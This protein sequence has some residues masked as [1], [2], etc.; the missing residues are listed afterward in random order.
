[1]KKHL[2]TLILALL[3]CFTLLLSLSAC[4]SPTSQGNQQAPVD[5]NSGNNPQDPENSDQNSGNDPGNNDPGV[6]FTEGLS[7]ALNEDGQSYTLVGLGS[8]GEADEIIIPNTHEGLSVTA[9]G[10]NAFQSCTFILRIIIPQTV[11]V[12]GSSAFENCSAL[13]DIT[14]PD[15]MASIGNNAFAGCTS[16]RYNENNG[17]LYIGNT[18]NPYL[19][20]IKVIDPS[21][22]AV[23]LHPDVKVIYP[24]AFEDCDN[25]TNV[26]MPD[27]SIFTP[28]RHTYSTE[29]SKN[30]THHWYD[31]TCEHTDKQKSYATHEWDNGTVTA[32][33]TCGSAGTLTYACICGATKTEDIPQLT[34]HSYSDRWSYDTTH[35]WHA[36]TCPHTDLMQDQAEHTWDSGTVTT[37]ATCGNAGTL[38]YACICGATKTEEIPQLTEHS[39]SDRWSYDTTHHWHAA[40]CSHSILVQDYAEHAWGDGTVLVSATCEMTGIMTYTCICGATKT[41][42]IPQLTEHPYSTAWSYDNTHHWHIAACAH[43]HLMQDYAEH[44]WGVGTVTLPATCT[45][46][47]T[48]TYTCICGHQKTAVIQAPGHLYADG[49]CTQCGESEPKPYTRIDADGTANASGEYILFGSYPQ[50]AVTDKTLQST[51]RDLAGTRPTSSNNY[52]WTS[53]GYYAKGSVK[54]YMWYID[55]SYEGELYRGVY[56]TEYRSDSTSS[57]SGEGFS[58][59]DN[60]GYTRSQIYWFRYE[61]I[62]WRILTEENG[63]AMLLCEMVIDAQEYYHSTSDR[64]VDEQT[65]YANNYAYSNIRAW[66]NDNFYH[67]AFDDLQKQIIQ[68]TTVDNSASTTKDASNPYA[69]ENTEDNVFLLS[70]ADVFNAAYGFNS[71]H[72]VYNDPALQKQTTDYAQCQGAATV[73]STGNGSWWLRSPA[74]YSIWD[75]RI[76]DNNG[77]ANVSGAVYNTYFGVCPALWIT[78]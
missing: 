68:L 65:V 52:K 16:L 17:S 26:T 46:D 37:P 64:T 44:T 27:G 12:I 36:A 10:D 51:L 33:A 34:E 28:H 5:N 39:Y 72:S 40:T 59:Q 11:T 14:I 69:C 66:L 56:F 48:M 57:G 2:F 75:E 42:E 74:E 41:E 29:W 71:D 38:T 67:T 4:K 47:G 19:V 20:L 73:S 23:E 49:Y 24:P 21:V 31:A 54:N 9:I 63:Q 1:M 25:L 76:V 18:G 58:H 8:A 70:Y 53:Y 78:L 60:N 45:E 50:S 15:N 6:Q 55:I 3:C 13:T 62:K 22:S 77:D 43:D 30:E 61:P 32:P 7:Y 35:H